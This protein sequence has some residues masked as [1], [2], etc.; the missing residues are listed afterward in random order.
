MRVLVVDPVFSTLPY[1]QALCDALSNQG[2]QVKILGRPLSDGQFWGVSNVEHVALDIEDVF[3][4]SRLSGLALK[5]SSAIRHLRFGWQIQ[6]VERVVA[7]FKP[8]VVH[9]QWCLTPQAEIRLV[10]RL[11]RR[12]TTLLTVHDTNPFNGS[13]VSSFVTRGLYELMAQFDHLI[14]H[15]GA[16]RDILAQRGF[17]PTRISVIPHGLLKTRTSHSLEEYRDPGTTHAVTCLMFGHIKHY[18]GVDI[19]VRAVA[20]M[21]RSSQ[22]RVRFVVAG[23]LGIDAEELHRL[24]RTEGVDDLFEFDFR[25]YPEAEIHA[26]MRSADIFVFPYR[27]VQASGVFT[28]VLPYGRPIIASHL[29]IFADNVQDGVN[30]FLVPPEDPAALGAALERLCGDAELRQ[31][32]G[33]RNL[34]LLRKYPSWTQIAELTTQAYA[35]AAARTECRRGSDV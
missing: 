19:L 9:F 3:Q 6:K 12:A 14:V 29:G 11:Q 33:R 16:A 7:V 30:G 32:M 18:K 27:E 2:H 21:T 20:T 4:Q 17:A 22:A 23:Q 5:V 26:L 13:R 1:D 28:M 35:G 24:C 25:F 10:R 8:D 34:E 31:S 15:T